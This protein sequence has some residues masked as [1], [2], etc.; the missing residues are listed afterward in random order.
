MKKIGFVDYYLGEWHANSYPAWIK[1][2][3]EKIGEEFVVKYAWAEKYISPWDGVNTDEWCEKFGAEKCETIEELCEK[4]DYILVLA[5]SHPEKHLGYAEKVLSYKKNTYIDKTFA[6]DL[7]TAE[8]IFA[9]AE[10]YGTKFFSSSAL[11]YGEELANVTSGKAMFTHGGGR[12]LLEY[13]IHQI[14]MVVKVL[15]EK[16]VRV[17][18]EK[19]GC[20]QYIM[21]VQFENEKQATMLYSQGYTFGVCVEDEDGK[22]QYITE[23][24]NMFP[25]L[26]EDILRFYLSGE[27]SFDTK[28]TLEAI[29]IRDG[30]IKGMENLGVW[31]DLNKN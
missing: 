28:E 17:R 14:E 10:K 25:H 9:I 8:K 2:A 20:S 12:I 27:V 24:S 1:D 5:P 16:A 19:Q 4:S 31:I 26:T 21:T 30:V 18:V 22:T 13:I 7:A 11:R 23:Q 6:P 29:K 3:S 15:K